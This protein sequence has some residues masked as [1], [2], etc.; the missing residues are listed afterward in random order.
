MVEEYSEMNE[1][2]EEIFVMVAGVVAVEGTDPTMV[3]EASAQNN[4][5]K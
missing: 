5:L 1:D 2:N 4:W 3:K